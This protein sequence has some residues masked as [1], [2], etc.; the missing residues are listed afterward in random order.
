MDD[1]GRERVVRALRALQSAG[2][3]CS[4]T[5]ICIKEGG[6]RDFEGHSAAIDRLQVHHAMALVICGVK[7]MRVLRC[8]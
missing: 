4:F 5:L 8:V 2:V 1:H 3:M 7:F 6:I